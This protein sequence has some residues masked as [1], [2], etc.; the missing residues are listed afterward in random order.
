MS[1][2]GSV[3]E[4]YKFSPSA[5]L[6]DGVKMQAREVP[7][8]NVINGPPPEAMEKANGLKARDAKDSRKE[9]GLTVRCEGLVALD[10][11]RL[12]PPVYTSLGHQS[13]KQGLRES[14]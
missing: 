6:S 12:T 9:E 11:G 13:R 5:S 4:R 7:L 3:T 1:V 14:R 8:R 10:P 2:T